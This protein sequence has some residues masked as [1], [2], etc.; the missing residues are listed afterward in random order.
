[1][2]IKTLINVIIY[3]HHLNMKFYLSSSGLGNKAKELIRLMPQNKKM[4]YIPNA[5]D[6]TNV[7][8]N[9]RNEVNKSDIAELRNLGLDVEFLDLKDYFGK[10]NKLRKK[11]NGLGGVFV[12]GGNT[13]ILRQSMRL[14]GFD[15]I[16]K[17]ILERDD[18]VY[19]G[20]SAGIC[21]LAPNF[22]ALQIVDD[23]MDN[24]YK[25]QETIWEGLGYLDYIILPHYKSNHPESADIDREI[26]YCK[27][28]KILFKTLKDGE[29]IIIK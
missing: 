27:K 19:A 13:F 4:G 3:A 16:F 20:Y 5:C 18:F 29:V 24:P 12:R 17:E 9:R 25:G 10:V 22:K 21:V 28:N 11:I 1:M 2:V 23:P 8:T 26:E 6:Y 7:D 15:I 14:S